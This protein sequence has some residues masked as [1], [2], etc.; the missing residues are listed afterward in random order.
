MLISKFPGQEHRGGMCKALPRGRAPPARVTKLSRPAEVFSRL[1]SSA[2][3]GSGWPHCEP[4]EL[5]SASHVRAVEEEGQ[6]PQHLSRGQPVAAAGP[7]HSRGP[8]SC[9]L[10]GLNPAKIVGDAASAPLHVC[11]CVRAMDVSLRNLFVSTCICMHSWFHN[12]N[13]YYYSIFFCYYC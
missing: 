11:N 3:P 4:C 10:K 7:S 6:A 12:Y 5:R 13:C 9:P 2:L 8:H 1:I